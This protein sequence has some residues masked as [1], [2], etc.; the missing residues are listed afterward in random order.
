[1]A[2]EQE[3]RLYGEIGPEYFG[4][5]SDT[6]V[7]RAL[8]EMKGSRR[9]ALRVNSPGGDCFMGVSIMNALKRH[10]AKITVHV[11][12]LAASAASIIAMGADKIVMHEGSMMMIHRA[13][14]IAM[15]NSAD[16]ASV[17]ETLSKV[18]ENLRDIYHRKSGLDK[19]KIKQM[20]DAETWLRA[21]EAVDL[22]LAD[23]MDSTAADA[24]AAA[25][26][27]WYSRA[28]ETISR[29]ALPERQKVAALTGLSIAAKAQPESPETIARR[30]H[31]NKTKQRLRLAGL[32]S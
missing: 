30:E 10:P 8:D 13:W 20:L 22:G 18:D 21:Q 19:A 9:I 2:E 25:P 26:E 7:I 15:G 6:A 27:G 4:M 24:T 3:L 29:Y 31:W 12:A 16:L 5:I 14:T 1:M 32:I 11:D 28:P 17:S 23:E